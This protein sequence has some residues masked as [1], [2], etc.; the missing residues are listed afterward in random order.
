MGTAASGMP[1]Q[2]GVLPAF[3]AIG[4][5][6][7]PQPLALA[8][9]DVPVPVVGIK[10][11]DAYV[12]P[13]L[14]RADAGLELLDE[15]DASALRS[16]LIEVSGDGVG[17]DPHVVPTLLDAPLPDGY[18]VEDVLGSLLG[19]AAQRAAASETRVAYSVQRAFYRSPRLSTAADR[20]ADQDRGWG[21]WLHA[22]GVETIA[23]EVYR[24]VG[25][26]TGES[27]A[28][29]ADDL[30][31]HE[32]THAALDAVALRL[33]A[34]T[35]PRPGLGEHACQPCDMEEALA[36]AAVVEH[37]R[38][39]VEQAAAA[40]AEAEAKL[41]DPSISRF[42][43]SL[44]LHKGLA[45]SARLRTQALRVAARL[46]EDRL[47]AAGGGYGKWAQYAAKPDATRSAVEEVL[48]HD[49]VHELV[50]LPLFD[51][52]RDELFTY[53]VPVHLVL[54]P[55]SHADRGEWAFD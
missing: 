32:L 37:S 48:R 40:Q 9:R 29:A 52:V 7:A 27:L 36:N 2:G 11:N 8:H 50:A 30:L 23:R 13:P 16:R 10:L 47:T 51:H 5:R 18:T 22:H 14:V 53:D 25:F 26:S 45:D 54:T 24:A 55:G 42:A 49:G 38:K 20:G 39:R 31:Q 28:L 41:L 17:V 34:A 6:C 4:G 15:A 21:I 44:E 46:T 12:M 33:E 1:M 35:G 3:N 43:A 19:Q